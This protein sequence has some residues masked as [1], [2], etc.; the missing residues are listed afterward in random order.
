MI[1]Y[2]RGGAGYSILDVTEPLEPI[3]VFSVYNDFVR[4]K[5]MIALSDGEIINSEDSPAPALDY[6]GGSLN[7]ND[8]EEAKNAKFNIEQAR[9]ADIAIDSTGNDYTERDKIRDCVTDSNFYSG[10]TAACYKG[11]VWRFPYIMPQEFIDDPSTLP[12]QK[13]ID[14]TVTSLTVDTIVQEAS[15]ATITFREELVLS[16]IHI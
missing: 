5:V 10:G 16:L 3:H 7:I 6:T 8:S 11:R 4:S 14:G 2:G 13:V 15:L 12:V 1:P 9:N